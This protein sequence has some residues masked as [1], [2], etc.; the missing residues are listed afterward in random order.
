MTWQRVAAAAAFLGVTR[1]A[2]YQAVK[3]G[4]IKAK[5]QHGLLLVNVATWK[6]ASIERTEA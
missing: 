6:G 3:E 1:Q 5:Q 4:R 2:V